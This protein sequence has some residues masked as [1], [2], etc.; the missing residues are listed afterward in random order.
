LP[1]RDLRY[2]NSRRRRA[3]RRI[4]AAEDRTSRAPNTRASCPAT[5]PG[6]GVRVRPRARRCGE[7]RSQSKSGGG[8]RTRPA[9]SFLDLTTSPDASTVQPDAALKTK[10]AARV[11][12][13]SKSR[14]TAFFGAES[15]PGSALDESERRKSA[16]IGKRVQL[17]ALACFPESSSAHRAFRG[18]HISTR[19]TFDATQAP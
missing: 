11:G 2:T 16:K 1:S 17:R 6:R 10:R 14:A 9:S 12:F 3:V 5:T 4:I 7:G 13:S 8:G 15:I 18:L 19:L